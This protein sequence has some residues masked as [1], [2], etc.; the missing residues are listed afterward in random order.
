MWPIA[1]C[2][3]KMLKLIRDADQKGVDLTKQTHTDLV[4]DDIL[5]CLQPNIALLPDPQTRS[6]LC[7]AHPSGTVPLSPWRL[8]NRLCSFFETQTVGLGSHT[9]KE[10]CKKRKKVY[11]RYCC[12]V[13][14]IFTSTISTGKQ[15]KKGNILRNYG[16]IAGRRKING[17]L[18][19]GDL[20]S[21]PPP[22]KLLCLLKTFTI[23]EQG[24]SGSRLFASGRSPVIKLGI[25]HPRKKERQVASSRGPFG[26]LSQSDL[27][28]TGSY[29][30]VLETSEI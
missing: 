23:K 15:E 12:S 14:R 16:K 30:C 2:R 6:R 22:Q 7:A 28:N 10:R 25:C 1:E 8:P 21:F 17:H 3:F 26:T 24:I 4:A 13:L 9:D 27:K 20:L 19:S 11:S 18:S 29:T 5:N